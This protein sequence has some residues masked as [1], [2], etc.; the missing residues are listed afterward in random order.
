MRLQK[1]LDRATLKALVNLLARLPLQPTESMDADALDA[2]S[3]LFCSYFTTFLSLLED[4]QHEVDRVRD[5]QTVALLRDDSASTL[6]LAILA[7]SNLLS[8]NVDVGL[9]FSLEIGYHQ[10]LEIRT[11]FMHVL[12]N[13]LTQGTEFSSLGDSAIGEKYERLINLLV[14]DH[15]FAYAL[16]DSCPSSEVDELAVALLNIFDSKGL[17]LTLLRELIEQE[18]KN[19]ESES[20]LMRRNCVATKMLSVFAKWKG[21]AYLRLTLQRVLERLIVSSDE[22]DLELDP[23]RTTSPEELQRN[24]LQLRFVTNVFIDEICKSVKNVPTSFR[25]I[26]HT[27]TTSVTNRFPEAKF[28]AVGAF[29]FLRFFCP[30]IV[31]PDSEGLVTSIPK[32]GMRRGLLLIA[33]V[34]QNLANNVL[35]GAK[36]PYMIPLNDFLTA[37]IYRITTFLR[38]ISVRF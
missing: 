5:L 11:A 29:I 32:K 14:K 21:A 15:K 3:Q 24:A 4:S 20:E 17:G 10:N 19:T 31:A 34:V 1:D 38:D 33:K 36:E 25:Y 37:N 22:L 27:I 9:K 30:A 16:C 26:C 35:F 6:E 2:K 13:I 8:A 12:T 23:A 18:V 7:L 28:T